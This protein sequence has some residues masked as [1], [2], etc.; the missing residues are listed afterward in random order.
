MLTDEGVV[1]AANVHEVKAGT[2][3]T[4]ELFGR[5][6]QLHE[7]WTA[8]FFGE[9]DRRGEPGRNVRFDRSKA[10]IIMDVLKRQ[11]LSPRYIQHSATVLFAVAAADAHERARILDAA[12]SP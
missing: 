8:P 9:Q 12:F 1:P 3:M 5:V 10:P 4:R 6:L 2:P 11:L 7:E